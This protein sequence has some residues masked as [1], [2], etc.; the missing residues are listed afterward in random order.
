[1]KIMIVDDE[2]LMRQG[3][4][5]KIEMSGLPVTIIAE[6]GD[7]LK[8]LRMLHEVMP[9][10]V[11]T[12]IRMPH[13]DGLEFLRE[14]FQLFPELQFIVISGFGE[15]EYAQKAI[16]YGVMDYLLKPVDKAELKESLIRIMDKIEKRIQ[17]SSLG[18]RFKHLQNRNEESLREQMLSKFIQYGANNEQSS[19]L[20]DEW[21]HTIKL[22]CSNFVAVVFVLDSFKLPHLSFRKQDEKLLWFAVQNIIS[23]VLEATGRAGVLFRHAMLENELV[24]V[25]GGESPIKA[26]DLHRELEEILGGIKLHLKLGATIGCGTSVNQ[27]DNIQQS[28]QQAKLALRNTI[29]HGSGRV[30]LTDKEHVRDGLH[31]VI[32]REDE[33]L[34]LGCLSECNVGAIAHWIEQRVERFAASEQFLFTHLESFCV[35]FHLLLRKYLL[36]QT[37]IPE[38]IIGD[39]DDTLTWLHGLKNW[40]EI[41]A[42]LIEIV[43]NII[44][45]LYKLRHSSEYSLIDDV[46]LYIEHSLHEPLNLQMIAKQ[47]FFN[48]SYFS[49]RFKEWF[50]ESLVNYLTAARIHKSEQL[51]EDPKLKIQ[52]VAELVGF[53]DAA[54]FSSVFRKSTGLTP[55]QFR[56]S[57]A[58]A[59][60]SL[61]ES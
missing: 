51:L 59:N 11:I 5:K 33:A 24:Y 25:L 50:G 17:H 22:S 49:R 18:E 6:V 8:A 23:I 57:A 45:H 16:Q 60:K 13:M 28:Y 43:E 39:L 53:N 9:D 55:N 52:Q 20:R 4:I 41:S 32:S 7:G 12:D 61:S 37:S 31:S 1:M 56:I 27:M 26:N 10:I 21:L 58:S 35:E 3:I 40:R 54:Y 47:F 2:Q 30:Y 46:K 34:L 19:A 42:Q 29:I 44:G 48:P 38:W 14:A 36:T 15:F